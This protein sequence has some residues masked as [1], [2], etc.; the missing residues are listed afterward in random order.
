M[1]G[2]YDREYSAKALAT[3]LLDECVRLYGGSPGDD[4]TVGVIKIREREQVNL[5]IGPPSDPKDLNK[6]MTLFFSK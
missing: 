4:T 2:V 3:L 1:E 5:M 6:M